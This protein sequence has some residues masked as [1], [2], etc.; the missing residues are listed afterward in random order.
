[1]GILSAF[2][3]ATILGPIIY[4]VIIGLVG[5]LVISIIAS[6]VT[7]ALGKSKIDS[8]LHGLIIKIVKG[9]LWIFVIIMILQKLGISTA[10]LVTV[11]GACGAAIAL[12]L[13]DSLGN[14]AGGILLILNKPFKAGDEVKIGD[15]EG[16]VDAIDLMATKLHTW[17]NK[18]VTVPNGLASTSVIMNYTESGLRRLE[19]Q[20]GV[21]GSSSI[22][23]V[24]E[25][26]LKACE[27]D[28]MF[29]QTPAPV[30]GAT[31]NGAGS[32]IFDCLV[33]C[34]STDYYAA[35]YRLRE[36]AAAAFAEAGIDAP[37]EPVIVTNAN[38]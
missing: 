4:A 37:S 28:P 31:G 13:K 3:G 11:I 14:L 7:K 30:V 17:D 32:I 38:N 23:A 27:S 1:M 18:I 36:A 25:A 24:K 34:K 12:G 33:W 22:T 20:F 9:L 16:V 10:S 26:L 2:T 8:S 29:V 6:A 35:R 19:E 15:A 21:S 5:W